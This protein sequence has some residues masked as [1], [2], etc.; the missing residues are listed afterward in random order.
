MPVAKVEPAERKPINILVRTGGAVE[1]GL[2]YLGSLAQLTGRSLLLV[3]TSPLKRSRGLDRSIHQAMATG[4]SAVPIV[5]LI[6]FFIGVI[7]ALQGAYELRKLG[8][9][10]FVPALVAVAI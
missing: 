7:M 3:F 6:T 8:A 9:M 10:Q 4:V 1:A 5:S 2:S